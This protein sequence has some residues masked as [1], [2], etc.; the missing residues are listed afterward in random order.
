MGFARAVCVAVAGIRKCE[1]VPRCLSSDGRARWARTVLW[2]LRM[3]VGELRAREK[4]KPD[5][6]RMALDAAITRPP[7]RVRQWL[8][9][10]AK[11]SESTRRWLFFSL[12]LLASTYGNGWQPRPPR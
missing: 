10:L 1:P 11:A 6:G 4:N 9:I 3:G 12:S 8:A 7:A 5:Q 2:E